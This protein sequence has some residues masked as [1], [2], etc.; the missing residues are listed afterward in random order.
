MNTSQNAVAADAAKT[1][2]LI[3]MG[4]LGVLAYIAADFIHEVLGHGSGCIAG[5]G[6]IRLLTSA[7]FR[8]EGG[9]RLADLMGP[10]ANLMAALLL[11]WPLR[12]ASIRS[13][14]LRY[15][16]MLGY[17]FNLFWASG[18]MI[19][20]GLTDHDDWSFVIAGLQ[21]A[22]AWHVVLVIAGGV[23]YAQGVWTLEKDIS[24]L[25]GVGSRRAF[26]TALIV[27]YLSAG[28]AACAAALLNSA[29]ALRS[30]GQVALET[31]AC[32]IGLIL[33]LRRLTL[34]GKA[35]TATPETEP[36]L[37]LSSCWLT[38]ITISYAI[39]A[40]VMGH[41]LGFMR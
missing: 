33:T 3:A 7:F 30:L 17:A 25:S 41:G 27:P 8:C 14:T 9:T 35:P 31:F 10:L 21:P 16:L 12:L 26:S 39:F 1:H 34:R 37:R 22:I 6:H 5:G 13:Q 36:T 19:Y 11:K 28:G 18:Q 20:S 40:L 29:E 24:G 23:L 15:A 4:A 38:A 2:G 32:N